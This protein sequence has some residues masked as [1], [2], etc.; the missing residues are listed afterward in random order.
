M[1][2][3]RKREK[4]T[5]SQQALIHDL[6]RQLAWSEPQLAGL[7]KRMYHTGWTGRLT[8][9]QASGMIEALKAILH[10]KEQESRQVA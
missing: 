8:R 1:P 7:I 4:I 5:P 3:V 9:H 10:R 2:W 6:R